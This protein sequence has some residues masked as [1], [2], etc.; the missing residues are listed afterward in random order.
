LGDN[1]V[2]ADICRVLSELP[3]Y[4]QIGKIVLREEE[5]VKNS[6]RKIKRG[7]IVKQ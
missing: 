5:F 6:S 1:D 3:P 2:N 7:E 4:K